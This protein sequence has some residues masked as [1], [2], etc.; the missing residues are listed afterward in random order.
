[1]Q[2]NIA[3]KNAWPVEKG[4]AEQIGNFMLLI[5]AH[6]KGDAVDRG[7]QFSLRLRVAAGHD[8]PG[9]GIGA[10]RPADELAGLKI[11]KSSDRAGVDDIGVG[12]SVK[13]HQ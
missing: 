8:D 10:Q 11:R 13:R 3:G 4:T 6:N 5:I 9:A 12:E 7:Q 1:L 2:K